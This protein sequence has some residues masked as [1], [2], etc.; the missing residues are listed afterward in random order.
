MRGL[1][2]G[3]ENEKAK[4]NWNYRCIKIRLARNGMDGTN[5]MVCVAANCLFFGFAI[6]RWSE[7]LSRSL[8]S[9][10]KELRSGNESGQNKRGCRAVF[11]FGSLYKAL[12]QQLRL[13]GVDGTMPAA[14]LIGPS[15]PWRHYWY[16]P[17]II[18]KFMCVIS[19]LNP[20]MS[21]WGV[22]QL[23]LHFSGPRT[24]LFMYRI[25]RSKI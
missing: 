2:T 12:N 16:S 18:K 10:L 24:F 17:R 25:S 8:R 14:F 3:R 4:E 6:S 11:R 5:G 21:F 19:I 23:L 22:T 7:P 1:G 13:Y 15:F 9:A 20:Q